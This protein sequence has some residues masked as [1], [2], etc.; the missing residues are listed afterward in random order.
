MPHTASI[1]IADRAWHTGNKN[2][3]IGKPNQATGKVM[4]Y[5]MPDSAARDPHTAIFE[6]SGMIWCANS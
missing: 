6:A 1:D 4:V 5:A 2:G 3:T